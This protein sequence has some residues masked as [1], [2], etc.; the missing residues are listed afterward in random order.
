[1]RGFFCAPDEC[2]RSHVEAHGDPKNRA[3]AGALNSPFKVT[4][5][6][7]IQAGLRMQHHLRNLALLS[8]CPHGLSKGF[9][10]SR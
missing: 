3:E 6:R 2:T 5:E 4:D 1:M 9:L 8:Y 7:S 10:N